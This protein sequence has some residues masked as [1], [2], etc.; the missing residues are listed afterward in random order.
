[1]VN[2]QIVRFDREKI[3]FESKL[4][5]LVSGGCKGIFPVSIIEDE[6]GIRGFYKTF[7]YKKLSC[8]ENIGAAEILTLLEKTVDAVEEC[9]QYL[10]FPEEFIISTETAYVDSRF[11]RIKFTYIPSRREE[12][13]NIKLLNFIGELKK[14]TTDN[15]RLYLN[16][17]E[18][19]FSVENL[20]RGKIKALFLRL[21]EEIKLCDIM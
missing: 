8:L 20:S 19:L 4:D 11:Q 12:S 9:E 17:A 13:R 6:E 21:R 1:M 2:E 14:L 15:G 7:G 5:F 16:M 18:E 10:I 3:C